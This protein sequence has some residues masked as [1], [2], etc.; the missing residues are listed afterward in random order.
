MICE[1]GVFSTLQQDDISNITN[2][3]LSEVCKGVANKS[4]FQSVT[5]ETLKYQ[6]ALVKN[7]TRTDVS[8]LGF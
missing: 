2:E 4:M 8:A 3:F 5:G 6:N 7:N 1:R